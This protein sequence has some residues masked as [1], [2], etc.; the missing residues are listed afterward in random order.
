MIER[1]FRG[2][3]QHPARILNTMAVCHSVLGM[4]AALVTTLWLSACSPNSQDAESPRGTSSQEA[5]GSAPSA[6]SFELAIQSGSVTVRGTDLDRTTVLR[7]LL[8]AERTAVN[9]AQ[10][11]SLPT[12]K[13]SLALQQATIGEALARL[14]P[15][16]SY[17]PVY[18]LATRRPQRLA[19]LTIGNAATVT[20]SAEPT[21]ASTDLLKAYTEAG[22]DERMD[23]LQ[24]LAITTDSLPVITHALNT[25]QDPVFVSR[26]TKQLGRA[27]EFGARQALLGALQNDN[28]TVVAAAL[29]AVDNWRDPTVEQNVRPLLAHPTEAIAERA[30]RML[31]EYSYAQEAAALDA[32]AGPRP[33]PDPET[34]NQQVRQLGDRQSIEGRL[35]RLRARRESP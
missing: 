12:L 18:E 4:T 25:E 17:T 29:E 24:T 7:S 35:Q 6:A 23:M 13:L 33:A 2:L 19:A 15:D 10:L 27:N 28:E 22:R 32:R 31:E 26:L 5:D 16:T 14:L 21:A 20:T 8:G 34:V 9:D 3:G 30:E 1:R 11:D